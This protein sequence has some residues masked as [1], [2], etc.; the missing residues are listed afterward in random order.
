MRL[1]V[2][3]QRYGAELNGGAELHARYLAEHLARHAE[4]E[5][6][7]TC[8][9]DYI[10]WRN[11]LDPGVEQVNGVPVRRFPVSR[12]RDVDDFGRRSTRVFEEP[13][14]IA[15]ELA[16]L[17]SEGPTSP[18]LVSHLRRHGGSYDYCIFFSYRY[19][20]AYHGIRVAGPRAVLV[21]TAERDPALGLA[22]FGGTFRAVRALMYNSYEE[23]TLINAVSHNEAVP[24]VVVGIG[25]DVPVHPEPQR[26]RQATGIQGP[27]VIYVGRIDEN[28]GCRQLFDYFQL[29]ARLSPQLTLVLIGNPTMPIPDHPRIRHLGY[30]TDQEKFDAIAA[31]DLLV[32]PSFYESLSMVTLEAWAL[33]RPVLANGRCD[34]LCGQCIRS[35]AGLYYE[36]YQEFAESL[37]TIL[38]NSA[39]RHALGVNG[40]AYFDANYTWP[41]IEQKYLDMLDRLEREDADGADRREPL[42]G[43]I[44]R[45]RRDLPPGRQV[46]DRLPTGP[47]GPGHDGV[48]PPGNTRDS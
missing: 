16:W 5:V 21:P 34:V 25:S 10:T 12:V 4:V 33:G 1:A 32:M 9:A 47:A 27:V 19:Y 15:A 43:W 48:G 35:N 26:F 22:I 38:S 20:H 36:S 44:G 31:A 41:V 7:T 23:R 17:R 29:Y 13:H 39:L 30:V 18:N 24:G 37:H 14:S 3:V 11:E 40:H 45:R 2:V 46:V 6:L 42:P 28:K 8:A